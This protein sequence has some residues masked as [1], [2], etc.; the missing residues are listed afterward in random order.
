MGTPFAIIC[1][2]CETSTVIP[3]SLKEP[4]W[5]RPHCLTQRSRTPITLPRRSV[6]KRFV[7]PSYIETMFSLSISGSTHSFL[8]Q[9]ADP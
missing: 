4:V 6:Q 7:P 9:M 2:T 3:R 8:P 5:L 1:F